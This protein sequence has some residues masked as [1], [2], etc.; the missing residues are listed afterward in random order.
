MKNRLLKACKREWRKWPE[1]WTK[2]MIRRYF[3]KWISQHGAAPIPSLRHRHKH[4]KTIGINVT[5]DWELRFLLLRLCF[6]DNDR[7]VWCIN[8]ARHF[9]VFD[10]SELKFPTVKRFSTETLSNCT[11]SL[12]GDTQIIRLVGTFHRR[13]TDRLFAVSR[14]KHLRS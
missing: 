11:Q 10:N 3:I 12:A 14:P 6:C 7:S 1:K 9:K 5:T 8:A 2:A 13:S 4:S